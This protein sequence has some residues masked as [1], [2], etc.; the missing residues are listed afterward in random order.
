MWTVNHYLAVMTAAAV[1]A[2]RLTV[3]TR[4]LSQFSWPISYEALAHIWVGAMAGMWLAGAGQFYLWVALAVTA[5]EVIC[6]LFL[7]KKEGEGEGPT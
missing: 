5:W 6:F 2:G 4:P 1:A 3:P 7:R